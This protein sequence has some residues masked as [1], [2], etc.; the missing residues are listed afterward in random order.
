MSDSQSS[1]SSS[2]SYDSASL[3]LPPPVHLRVFVCRFWIDYDLVKFLSQ[4]DLWL[5]NYSNSIATVGLCL[6]C[7]K[8]VWL[9]MLIWS[10]RVFEKKSSYLIFDLLFGCPGLAFEIE[11]KSCAHKKISCFVVK[12]LVRGN[13]CFKD[14]FFSCCSFYLVPQIN[15][16]SVF[17]Y[18]LFLCFI[19]FLIFTFM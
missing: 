7:G 14:F 5:V 18:F 9:C 6:I 3:G 2:S 10:R 13:Y 4:L 11:T 19:Y 8:Q 1:S 12:V 17:I 16:R 15:M